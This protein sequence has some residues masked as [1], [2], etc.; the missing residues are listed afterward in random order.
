MLKLSQDQELVE[1]QPR[2]STVIFS[3]T[4]F[5]SPDSRVVRFH[6]ALL[7]EGAIQTLTLDGVAP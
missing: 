4:V 5:A 6:G 1:A 3:L 7:S 2:L